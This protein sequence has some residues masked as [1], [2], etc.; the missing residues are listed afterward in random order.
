MLCMCWADILVGYTGQFSI[1]HAGFFAVAPMHGF[2][3]TLLH[4]PFILALVISGLIAAFLAFF[5]GSG[6]KD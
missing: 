6:I 1:G 5:W 3:M 4:L 2:L